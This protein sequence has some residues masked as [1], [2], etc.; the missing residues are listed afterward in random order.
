MEVKCA[1]CK[2]TDLSFGNPKWT[3]LAD[4]FGWHYQ[5][6]AD[7]AELSAAI[8]AADYQGPSLIVIPVDYSENQKLTEKLGKLTSSI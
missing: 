5:T 8:Q 6:A 2:H 7:S 3:S 1:L 4:A